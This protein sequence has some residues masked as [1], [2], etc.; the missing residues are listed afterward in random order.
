VR[1]LLREGEGV[2]WTIT[3][4]GPDGRAWLW[5]RSAAKVAYNLGVERL[6]GRPVALSL[7]ALVNGIG[8]FRAEL[9]AAFHSGRVKHDA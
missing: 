9:Y 8:R 7:D 6:T 2:Y 1:N 3:P 4:H 5:L